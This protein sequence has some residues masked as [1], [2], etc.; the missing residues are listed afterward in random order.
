MSLKEAEGTLSAFK[1]DV[2]DLALAELSRLD[3]LRQALESNLSAV[4]ADIKAL[5]SV[6]RA[7]NPTPVKKK[8]EPSKAGIPF[9]MSADREAEFCA[10]IA[11]REDEIT[12]RTMREQFPT[13][14]PSYCNMALKMMRETGI[15]RLSATTGGQH[16]YRSLI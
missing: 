14:S 10:W 8:K 15:L 13:W 9:V 5:K 3:D 7:I 11:G 1:S 2:E 16:I 12:S 4:N 6:L